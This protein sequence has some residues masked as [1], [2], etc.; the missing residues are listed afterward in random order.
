MDKFSKG[1]CTMDSVILVVKGIRCTRD[2]G[3]THRYLYQGWIS[4]PR[5]YVL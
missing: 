2:E 3:A 1:I 4:F 5:G